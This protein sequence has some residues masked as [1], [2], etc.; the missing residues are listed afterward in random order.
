MKSKKSKVLVIA[1]CLVLVGVIAFSFMTNN[2]GKDVVYASV[3]VDADNKFELTMI[4]EA[5]GTGFGNNFFNEGDEVTISISSENKSEIQVGIMLLDENENPILEEFIGETILLDK[6]PQQVTVQVP[7]D[8]FYRFQFRNSGKQ[9]V[10]ANGEVEF[11][12]IQVDTTNELYIM[13]DDNAPIGREFGMQNTDYLDFDM[14][15]AKKELLTIQGFNYAGTGESDFIIHSNSDV[16]IKNV[17]VYSANDMEEIEF[18]ALLET[19]DSQK[20]LSVNDGKA[21]F[22]F[23]DL[24]IDGKSNVLYFSVGL[25]TMSP[26]EYETDN[27]S[28]YTIAFNVTEESKV[29]FRMPNELYEELM[30]EIL[31]SSIFLPT[32]LNLTDIEKYFF[33][34]KNLTSEIGDVVLFIDDDGNP[35]AFRP[36]E[37]GL[38]PISIGMYKKIEKVSNPN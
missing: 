23:V 32:D 16:V 10:L 5:N 34:T 31:I 14:D 6:E 11:E 19:E 36:D 15:I 12:T 13:T 8:D 28:T 33:I 7:K 35:M 26:S 4:A 3:V 17:T 30:F 2:N 21:Y 22:Y 27:T 1:V 25:E 24:E 38:T 9:D 29:E 20:I 37:R 18:T